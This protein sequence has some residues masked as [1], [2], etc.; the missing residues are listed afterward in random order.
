[1]RPDGA[2]VLYWMVAFRRPRWNFALQHAVE[3]ARTLDRP[4]VVLEALR[5]GY[6][7]ASERLHAFVLQGMADNARAFKGDPITY[8]PYVEPTPGA[9]KGLLDALA[10]RACVVVTDDFPGF[11]IPHMLAAAAA[12][13]AVLLEAVDSNGLLPL[14]ATGRVFSAAVAFR[15]FL[16]TVLPAHLEELPFADPLAG[17]TLRRLATLP[18]EVVNRWPPAS[19]G[20]LACEPAA[21]GA[22]PV[23]HRV[24]PVRAVTGGATV[25]GAVLRRFLNERLARYPEDR[26][27]PE[28][29]GGSGL[30]PYLHFGHLSVHEVFA[31]VAGREGWM[32]DRLALK[33][34]GKRA[35]WWRMSPEAEAFADQLVTWREL[36]FNFVSR[37]EDGEQYDS[38]PPWALATLAKHAGDPRPHLYTPDQ[39]E[40]AET[41]DPLW[42]AAQAEL[43]RDGRIHTYLRMLW[44]KK[45]L[46]W[47]PSPQQ[48]L[49]VML[50]LNNRYA[51][52]GRD[53]NSASGVLWCLGRYDRPWGPERPVFGTVRFMSSENTARKVRV[54]RYI[55]SHAP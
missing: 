18:A 35:G 43:L 10:A 12:H 25:A 21:L 44:G 19:P 5:A 41:H 47:S 1:V 6:P 16:Q 30:S 49:A 42:N 17:V 14:A 7:W 46:E 31:A 26:N 33:A 50:E 34:S 8:V 39:L 9:G 52:D 51:L 3:Y 27:R 22:L 45:I 2:Y 24:A 37:R 4:L 15:R 36:G 23:D 38:L 55:A 53:P 13:L 40:M 28:A 32:P 54:T 29:Q 11:F 48:A 20:L